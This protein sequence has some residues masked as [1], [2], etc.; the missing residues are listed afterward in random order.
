MGPIVLQAPG[1]DKNI[2]L[3]PASGRRDPPR[4]YLDTESRFP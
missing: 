2:E 1:P 3:R 4:A